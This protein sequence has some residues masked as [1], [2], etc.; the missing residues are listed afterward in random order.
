MGEVSAYMGE[1]LYMSTNEATP[2]EAVKSF[3][4]EYV[5]YNYNTMEST[6]TTGH[7]T[8]VKKRHFF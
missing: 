1:N 3:Y 8:Q 2:E 4:D 5:Y 6:G 7:Y